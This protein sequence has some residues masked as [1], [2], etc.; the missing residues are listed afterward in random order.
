[1]LGAKRR[2]EACASVAGSKPRRV[3]GAAEWAHRPGELASAA[4]AIVASIKAGLAVG[5][6]FMDDPD[7]ELGAEGGYSYRKHRRYERNPA[8]A[9]KKKASVR[10]AGLPLICEACAFD[11]QAAYGPRGAEYIEVHH[12]KPVHTIKAG[13]VPKMSDLALLCSNCHRMAHRWGKLMSVDDLAT[14]R[15]THKA[16]AGA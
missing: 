1:M 12:R 11:F 14:L 2:R 6:A 16:S 8:N 3:P 15:Q 7:T 9:R 13:T 5:E 10:K 4:A